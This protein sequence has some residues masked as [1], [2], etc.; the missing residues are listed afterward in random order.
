M[1]IAAQHVSPEELMALLDHELSTAEA[2]QVSAHLDECAECARVAD[3]LRRTSEA[4]SAWKVSD[5]PANVGYLVTELAT[6]AKSGIDIGKSALSIR[7]SFWGW[8]Q[9]T[10]VGVAAVSALVILVAIATPN[11]MRPRQ[12]A[13][14]ASYTAAGNKKRPPAMLGTGVRSAGKLQERRQS[15]TVREQR[16]APPGSIV[17]GVLGGIQSRATG[18]AGGVGS[19]LFHGFE[20]RKTS[21]VSTDGQDVTDQWNTPMIARAV[22]LSIVV[23]DFTGSRSALDALIAR[24]RGYAAQLSASTTENAPRSMQAS[25]RIPASALA[26]AVND[27][28]GLGRVEN[29]AQSGEEVTYQHADLVQRLRNS[30]ETE[31]RLRDILQQRTGK[32][33]DVLKVEEEIARVRG[34]I[35]SMQAEQKALE[36]RVDFATVD[37]QLTEE[38]KAQLN[39]PAPS[40]WTRMNNALVA[41][42][43]N[44]TDTVLGILLFFFENGPVVILWLTVLGIPTMLIWRRYRRMRATM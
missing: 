6:K 36:H 7:V 26:S 38:Y 11:L 20:D 14:L 44:L 2:R 12:A 41:G 27:M 35:E 3:Q 31:E 15:P 42:Y 9:W 22:S 29:E 39:P 18:S 34:E 30:R 28:K 24:Y 37:L 4:M 21:L 43:H 32:I 10:G 17:G 25:L 40:V 23:R 16:I 8:K 13:D 33:S 19:G 1:T 5:V